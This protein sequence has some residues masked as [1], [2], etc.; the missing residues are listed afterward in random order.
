MPAGDPPPGVPLRHSEEEGAH[1]TVSLALS[2]CTAPCHIDAPPERSDTAP[3]H[4]D[5]PPELSDTAQPDEETNLC[6]SD[7]PPEL[8]D[9]AQP[10]QE[11]HLCHSDTAPPELSDTAQPN[12]ETHLCHS[13]T[14]LC[15]GASQGACAS[16]A[17]PRCTRLC[18]TN[19]LLQPPP[20]CLSF[21]EVARLVSSWDSV[22]AK[23]AALA[24]VH[25]TYR[26]VCC[27][28]EQPPSLSATLPFCLPIFAFVLLNSIEYSVLSADA[29]HIR[30][31]AITLVTFCYLIF[32][33]GFVWRLLLEEDRCKRVDLYFV[34]TL[35]IS[36]SL[37][38]FARPM[39]YALQCVETPRLA[40]RDLHFDT[41]VL[42][43]AC[44]WSALLIVAGASLQL[45]AIL[46][47]KHIIVVTIP[48]PH[49]IS[50]P[51]LWCVHQSQ[52]ADNPECVWVGW[53]R[54]LATY[55]YGISVAW[56][57]CLS[58]V[59]WLQDWETVRA[60]I[61]V[62][63]TIVGCRVAYHA[64]CLVSKPNTHRRAVYMH[65]H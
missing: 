31:Q 46:Y 43:L 39:L 22:V 16:D 15:H 62:F 60:T 41:W 5:A 44:V 40:P 53:Y 48:L 32:F 38:R 56:P 55:L 25:A 61:G 58:A 3:C 7:S 42:I 37:L 14:A 51:I 17:G 19:T 21:P 18:M 64:I 47:S 50:L 13:D 28:L 24:C 35:I 9:T 2:D 20:F 63:C 6:H 65:Q 54:F 1:G 49:A 26:I 29:H 27:W 52:Q 59:G 4:S 34:A 30:K 10:D 12:E 57:L 8:S 45:M 33:V 36:G 11:T 23:V